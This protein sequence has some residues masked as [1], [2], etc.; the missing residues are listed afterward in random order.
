MKK[1]LTI[2]FTLVIAFIATNVQA[3]DIPPGKNFLG[4][5][6][7]ISQPV[8]VFKS[9]DYYDNQAGLARQSVTYGI[10]WA[11]YFTKH[12]AGVI[13]FS[14]QDQGRPSS[15]ALQGLSNGY[16]A[17]FNSETTTVTITQ[18][19]QNFNILLGPQYSFFF[20]KFSL[21]LGASAGLLKS[22]DTPEYEVN[23]YKQQ[24]SSTTVESTTF[25]QRSSHASA[26]AYSGNIGLKLNLSEGFGFALNA[27]YVGCDGIA[28]TN[29]SN[30]FTN[31]R[32]QT[33]Q[34]I[35]VVQGT[36][37]IFFHF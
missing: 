21:D 7:G 5:Y 14:F 17:D 26:F 6:A 22:F 19:Y 23:V 29:E 4:L 11:H 24:I 8:G 32:L 9:T 37:G 3:Q 15:D 2:L 27:K 33:K 25:Y 34:P 16:N 20:G 28:I 13:D 12:V 35:N 10:S 18:R 31:G 1:N 36:L 30:T